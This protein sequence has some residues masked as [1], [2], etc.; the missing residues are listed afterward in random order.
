MRKILVSSLLIGISICDAALAYYGNDR[1]E[2]YDSCGFSTGSAR[3]DSVGRVHYYDSCGF[4]KGSSKVDSMGVVHFY[5]K[6]GFETGS[7]KAK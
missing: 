1:V 4:E 5:D 6:C 7:A 2:F 3:K